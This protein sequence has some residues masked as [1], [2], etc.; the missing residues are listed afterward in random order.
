MFLGLKEGITYVKMNKLRKKKSLVSSWEGLVLFLNYL[1]GNG[2]M[3]QDEGR[4]MCIVKS[5]EERLWD[6]LCRDLQPYYSPQVV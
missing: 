1:D 4:R 2:F 3:E 5:R 6:R